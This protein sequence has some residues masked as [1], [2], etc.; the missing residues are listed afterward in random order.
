MGK[1]KL[2]R[3]A[4][5]LLAAVA[6]GA[7]AACGGVETTR[8]FPEKDATGRWVVPG[9]QNTNPAP[10][11]IRLFELGGGDGIDSEQAIGVN[12]HLWRASLD[13]LSALPLAI[14][15][16][17]GGVIT[18]DWSISEEDPNERIK[19]MA[20]IRSVR[21]EAR[22]LQVTVHRQTRVAA[23]GDWLTAEV[24]EETTRQIV[25]SIL[26]QAREHRIADEG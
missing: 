18:T 22:S 2:T 9:R 8:E 1:V 19:V 17:F 14:A 23:G 11:G 6:A 3:A 13:V 4:A 25:D 26:N 21:L 5:L 15:D 10:E 20:H 16:P 12:K 7:V 24:A